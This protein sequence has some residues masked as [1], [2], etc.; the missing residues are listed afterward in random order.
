M[1]S[2]M[3]RGNALVKRLMKCYYDIYHENCVAIW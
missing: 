2:Y 1:M 3:L